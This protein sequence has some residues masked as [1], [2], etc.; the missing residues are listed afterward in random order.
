MK[1]IAG[2]V[3]AMVMG[4]YAWTAAAEITITHL[5]YTHHGDRYHAY[6]QEKAEEFERLNPGIEVEIIIGLHDKFQ[7]MLLGGVAPDVM[8]LPDFAYLGPL[9]QLVDVKPLLQRDGLLRAYNQAIIA[10]LT[11]PN[12]AIYSVPFELG[13][14]ITFFNRDLF[15]QHGVPTPDRLGR[16]WNWDTVVES[17]KKLTRDL[18]GDGVPDIYGV[19]RP[20]GAG[21]R[22]SVIQ[23]GGLFNV[24][25][26]LLRPVRSLW[27]T[28]EVVTAV[29]SYVR[30][31]Q[32]GITQLYRV[33]DPASYYFW[34]GKTAID[35]QDGVGIIGPYLE[36]APFDWDMAL[37]PW[38][39]LGPLSIG[40]GNGPH[41]LAETKHLNETWEWVKFYATKK[42]NV[43]QWVRMTGRLPCLL[44]SLPAYPRA[45]G[46]MDKNY[47]AIFDQANYLAPP[48]ALYP[49]SNELNP[50]RISMD[51]VW[52][53]TVAPITHLESIHRR[54][55]AII[56]DSLKQ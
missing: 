14:F 44:S 2:F 56:E 52:R 7:A 22:L 24:I 34:T 23:N 12:G 31:F 20:T 11:A 54:V 25:A 35:V 26:E 30:I 39:K 19:D 37:L 8:D 51:P 50:R 18:N 6:L 45:L 4:L 17:G 15:L 29:E 36:N 28:P 43:D 46:I 27:T 49:V 10:G 53:G 55:T 38:G 40:G 48:E 1:R 41:I 3:L 9:G 16:D 5:T 13:L 47:A 42:E 21:W 33:G 32:E